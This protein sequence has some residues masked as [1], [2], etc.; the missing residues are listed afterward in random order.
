MATQ[1]PFREEPRIKTIGIWIR[2]STEDQAQGESPATHEKRAR[3]YAEAK[4]WNVAEVY[5]LAGISGKAVMEHPEAKRMLRDIE[6]GH[7]TG[8][9]FSKLARLARNTKELLEFS[10]EFRRCGADLISL[11]EAIDTS[12]PAG[13][14][15]YT[16]IAA[17]AQWEREE[18]ASRIQAS[19]PIR[20]KSG[21]P[22][23]GSV[24]FGYHSKDGKVVPHPDHAPVRRLMY[25]LFLEHRR[26]KAVARIL[27][28]RG[29]RTASGAEWT[30]TT[31]SRLLRDPTAKGVYRS[32]Y[33]YGTSDGKVG[34]K[35]ESEWVLHPIEPIVSVELWDQVN[36][37]LA[38]QRDT[39]QKP[40]RSA[41]HLFAGLTA[42]T[43]GR[44]MYVP[45]RTPA[46]YR[47]WTCGTR[48]PAADLE[49]IYHEELRGFLFSD[50]QIA[51]Q[52]DRMDTFLAEKEERIGYL[53]RER[54]KV[55]KD[56]NS[57]FE[58]YRAGEISPAGF[59][60]RNRPL[61][62]R[63]TELDDLIPTEQASADILRL[64][65]VNASQVLGQARDLHSRWESLSGAEKRVVVE[66]ITKAITIGK[67]EVH[68]DLHYVP[69]STPSGSTGGG[70]DGQG[71]PEI[72]AK[73]KDFHFHEI[74]LN[75]STQPFCLA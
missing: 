37:I 11:A 26:K 19:I 58:L 66:A 22:L 7:I 61:E 60:A 24:P 40:G 14:L 69:R 36:G 55:A 29:Y 72:Q 43:C 3:L 34:L 33:T 18:I 64:S 54:A 27:N 5:D 46:N 9:I 49:A 15:F 10:E 42:C 21:K 51:S 31:I 62:A 13:R 75:K 70:P 17:M 8:L 28:E 12:S 52:Q 41:V 20:A 67:E 50:D 38:D 56:M 47:C 32:N 65:R 23:S 59:G 45:S 73:S 53:E 74:A 48:I 63:L 4:G 71:R 6:R 57:V 39:R 2:V 68:I 44:K 1:K 25:E 35:P 16:M 30:Y